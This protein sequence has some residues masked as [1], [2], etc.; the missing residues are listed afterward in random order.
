MHTE[1]EFSSKVGSQFAEAMRLGE[2]RTSMYELLLPFASK[3][4]L[5]TED[6]VFDAAIYYRGGNRRRSRGK[7][8]FI[9]EI[10]PGHQFLR[11]A[12]HVANSSRTSN[13]SSTRNSLCRRKKICECDFSRGM[14]GSN[15]LFVASD[16]FLKKQNT[17]LK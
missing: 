11:D 12:V 2:E 9:H 3:N 7:P 1:I 6:I 8:S 4:H 13:R 17:I 16:I 5:F 10:T 15:R 14:A